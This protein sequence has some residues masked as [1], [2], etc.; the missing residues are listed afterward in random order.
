MVSAAN[1]LT[2]NLEKREEE[3]TLA[4]NGREHRKVQFDDTDNESSYRMA[5]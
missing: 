4:D 3:A 5:N 1:Q 2:K